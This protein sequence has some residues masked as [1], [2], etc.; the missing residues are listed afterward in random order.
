MDTPLAGTT[1]SEDVQN[2]ET[3]L[4]KLLTVD[5]SKFD[6][7]SIRPEL[8]KE[9]IIKDTDFEEPLIFI[10][11]LDGTS[12][13]VY[14]SKSDSKKDLA[15]IAVDNHVFSMRKIY[16]NIFVLGIGWMFFFMS[17]TSLRSIQSS[18]NHSN[19]IGM[20]SLACV[21][22]GFVLACAFTSTIVQRLGPK[23]PLVGGLFCQIIFAVANVYP[24][25]YTLIPASIIAG[26]TQTAMWTAVGSITVKLAKMAASYKKENLNFYTTRFFGV[27]FLFTS[28]A[29]VL[30]SLMT[31][32]VMSYVQNLEVNTSSIVRVEFMG[33]VSVEN[34]TD[35]FDNVYNI[36]ADDPCGANFCH[37]ETQELSK[38]EIS[39]FLRYIITGAYTGCMIMGLAVFVFLLDVSRVNYLEHMKMKLKSQLLSLFLLWKSPKLWMI[40]PVIFFCGLQGTFMSAEITKVTI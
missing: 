33:N 25:Y 3:E 26:F 24:A 17:F 2:N 10:S 9:N 30:G 8:V 23:W 5:D 11:R 39:Q 34:A 20:I 38:I 1:E 31:S 13:A 32:L 18:I 36:I 27:F 14:V 7:L 12:S 15:D 16:K 37:H 40:A 4:K 21:Y 22:S 28:F 35:V 6:P 19:N 29:P